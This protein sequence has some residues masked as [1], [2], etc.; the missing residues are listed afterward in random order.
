MDKKKVTR[1]AALATAVGGLAASP[2]VLHALRKPPLLGTYEKEWMECLDVT[3]VAIKEA[4][5]VDTSSIAFV[6]PAGQTYRFAYLSA[7][8]DGQ[9]EPLAPDR[10]PA[11]FSFMEG[12]FRIESD[13]EGRIVGSG[14]T[15]VNRLLGRAVSRDLP[16]KEWR[17]CMQENGHWISL[18]VKDASPDSK[19]PP[20]P[21]ALT[22]QLPGTV[23]YRVG[24]SGKGPALL[25]F[26]GIA[27]P[28]EATY[29]IVGFADVGGVESIKVR[30]E[31]SP[32]I[33]QISEESRHEREEALVKLGRSRSEAAYLAS[34]MTRE[35][36]RLKSEA[37]VSV[38]GLAYVDL[39]T[40]V[41]LRMEASTILN[42]VVQ[43]ASSRAVYQVF[44][45]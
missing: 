19:S 26:P 21:V 31:L 36:A 9:L 44:V 20:F 23:E 40:G 5:G 42:D 17:L 3:K 18:D 33:G 15:S 10:V 39:R 32:D 28:T 4:R 27:T 22:L 29:R 37:T 2:F 34:G 13:G 38:Q 43:I 8:Y 41:T 12:S 30:I 14:N 16:T 45:S 24:A 25:L 6:P 11:M 35:S 1:R 7:S